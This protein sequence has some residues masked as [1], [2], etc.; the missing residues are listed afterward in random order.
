MRNIKKGIFVL[1]KVKYKSYEE[2]PLMLSV[3]ELATVLGISRTSAY[4]LTKDKRFPSVKI[5]SRVV[6]PKDKF[7]KWIE[8]NTGGNG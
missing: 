7:I 2:L 3:K 1:D 8:M 5:G 6:I 4:E